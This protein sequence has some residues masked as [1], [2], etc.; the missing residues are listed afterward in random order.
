MRICMI[1]MRGRRPRAGTLL[2]RIHMMPATAGEPGRNSTDRVH[3]VAS[4]S[5]SSSQPDLPRRDGCEPVLK[6]KRE[7]RTGSPRQL[8]GLARQLDPFGAIRAAVHALAELDGGGGMSIRTRPVG[9]SRELRRQ[10]EA[11]TE[12]GAHTTC[13]TARSA[14]SRCRR[15]RS[16]RP[17]PAAPCADHRAAAQ[18][19]DDHD[20]GS[21]AEAPPARGRDRGTRADQAAWST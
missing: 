13:A 8:G 16:R 18:R 12:R 9:A 19:L 6:S 10:T 17:S 14:V 21:H 11:L 7:L 20:T 3:R 4:G 15:E 1:L 5:R 2:P